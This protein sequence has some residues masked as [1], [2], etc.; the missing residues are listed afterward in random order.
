MPALPDRRFRARSSTTD[1]LRLP[2]HHGRQRSTACAPNHRRP[3]RRHQDHRCPD[4]SSSHADRFH[5]PQRSEHCRTA[6]SEVLPSMRLAVRIAAA[7]KIRGCLARLPRLRPPIA[8]PATRAAIRTKPPSRKSTAS[9][10]SSRETRFR[11]SVLLPRSTTTPF[12]IA[13]ANSKRAMTPRSKCT[14]A[15]ATTSPVRWNSVRPPF[16]PTLESTPSLTVSATR[17]TGGRT[18]PKS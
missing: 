4:R 2:P 16:L 14:V 10:Y 5:V 17:P 1:E 8:L 18:T 3:P 11:S 7:P 13:H 15:R 9:G 6:V 12:A